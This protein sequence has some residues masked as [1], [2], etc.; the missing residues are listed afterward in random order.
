VSVWSIFGPIT[1]SSKPRQFRKSPMAAALSAI[2]RS[3]F[4]AVSGMRGRRYL[5]LLTARLVEKVASITALRNLLCLGAVQN[6]AGW[7]FYSLRATHPPREVRAKAPLRSSDGKKDL[8]SGFGKGAPCSKWY[9]PQWL[10]TIRHG[11]MVC[12]T[13]PKTNTKHLNKRTVL[14]TCSE[15]L[16]VK[17]K[18]THWIIGH[19]AQCSFPPA[20]FCASWLSAGGHSHGPPRDVRRWTDQ[21][22]EHVARH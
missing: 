13:S 22:S 5:A 6:T 16:W 7:P 4:A 2:M 3:V 17:M 12:S 20:A 1:T 8:V 10:C 21:N 15:R 19:G 9:L 14:S 11:E 18:K